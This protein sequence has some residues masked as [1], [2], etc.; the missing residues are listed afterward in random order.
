VLILG[1]VYFKASSELIHE[2]V[3]FPDFESVLDFFV[4]NGSEVFF[5]ICF[6]LYFR[7]PLQ[8]FIIEF[9]IAIHYL[10]EKQLIILHKGSK[11][12]FGIEG[13]L[14]GM[15][16]VGDFLSQSIYDLIE[17]FEMR[18]ILADQGF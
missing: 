18:N 1:L 13:D 16:R 3:E 9:E 8:V 17:C 2:G 5:Q 10:L 12:V 14:I 6:V 4:S 15:S 7:Y 11:P